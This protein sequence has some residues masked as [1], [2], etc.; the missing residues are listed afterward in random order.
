[1]VHWTLG[2]P[3]D[4]THPIFLNTDFESGSGMVGTSFTASLPLVGWGTY[5]GTGLIAPVAGLYRYEAAMGLEPVG[6][7]DEEEESQFMISL[8]PIHLTRLEGDY[9]LY[10]ITDSL[11]FSRNRRTY[12]MDLEETGSNVSH[13]RTM[14]TVRMAAGDAL[15]LEV[16]HSR[17]NAGTQSIYEEMEIDE[18]MPRFPYFEMQWISE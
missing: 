15:I 12:E 9:D 17:N 6:F 3:F 13:L 10:I 1:V 2:T 16:T 14:G 18:S 7:D 8:A 11:S 4:R 5:D